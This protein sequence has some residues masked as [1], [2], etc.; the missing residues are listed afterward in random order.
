MIIYFAVF[1]GLHAFATLAELTARSLAGE[2]GLSLT[3]VGALSAFERAFSPGEDGTGGGFSLSLNP[4]G[5]G[6]TILSSFRNIFTALHDF[7]G[8]KGY[9]I[10]LG[11]PFEIIHIVIAIFGIIIIVTQ[12]VRTFGGA[13]GGIAGSIG[14]FFR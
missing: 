13:I 10:A 2:T 8:F 5:G 6:P 12:L 11:G 9:A 4:F 7:F 14:S 1:T 3:T